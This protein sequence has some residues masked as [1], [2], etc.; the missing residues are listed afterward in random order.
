M[1]ALDDQDAHNAYGAG[2]VIPASPKPKV[3]WQMG[4]EHMSVH[5]RVWGPQTRALTQLSTQQAW[6]DL[7]SLTDR[8]ATSEKRL[9]LA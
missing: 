9:R 3:C 7:G 8:L 1:D 2:I 4:P 6:L 5:G